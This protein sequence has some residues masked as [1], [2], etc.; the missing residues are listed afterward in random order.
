MSKLPAVYNIR[1][2]VCLSVSV[3][4]RLPIQPQWLYLG[5]YIIRP[6]Y[7]DMAG[8]AFIAE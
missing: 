6:R 8:V 2:S 1:L 7:A 4:V 3:I 5:K